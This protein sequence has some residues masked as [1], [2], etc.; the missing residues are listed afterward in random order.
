M[1]EDNFNLVYSSPI[2]LQDEQYIQY[3]QVFQNIS[4]I[5]ENG[6]IAFEYSYCIFGDPKITLI[7]AKI[8]LYEQNS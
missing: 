3:F 7:G 1:F 6:L 8:V 4:K 2:L 5:G